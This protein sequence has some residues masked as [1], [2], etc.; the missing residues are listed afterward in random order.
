M[1]NQNSVKKI[2]KKICETFGGID[3]LISN[4]GAAWQGSI[5]KVSDSL[6]KKSFDLNFYAHQYLSQQIIKIFLA[7]KTQG[8]LL[9]NISKQSIDPGI[10]FGPYGLPKASTLFLMRQYA[11]EYGKFGIRANGV[12][13]DRIRSGILTNKLISKRAKARGLN[14]KDYMQG[15][16]LHTEVWA[17]D[18]AEAFL[19][20]AKSKKT[21]GNVMTVDGGN[22]SSIL[23]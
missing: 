20:L 18:V 15:N 11:L 5:G 1:T 6:L 10:N 2:I 23:R 19:N 8:V 22:M 12:N 9:Y 13:A 16:L 21:T 4:A 14:K 17:E 3:I 7:Q